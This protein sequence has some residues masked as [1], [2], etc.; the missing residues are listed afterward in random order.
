MKNLILRQNDVRII[1][2]RG[3]DETA[4]RTQPRL[5]TP[6]GSYNP[7]WAVLIDCEEGERLY[8][9]VET[10]G[11]LLPNGLR[12]TVKLTDLVP[13]QRLGKSLSC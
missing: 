2:S 13:N 5:P 4:L 10:K 12:G 9:V 3:R 6:G 11:S 8:F 7:D 1:L